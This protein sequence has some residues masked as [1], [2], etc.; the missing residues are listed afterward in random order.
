[1][2]RIILFSVLFSISFSA[3]LLVPTEYSTIQSGIDASADGDTVL[4]SA[5]TYNESLLLSGKNIVLESVEGP[6][7]TIIDAGQQNDRALLIENG[8]NNST[9]ISGFR[10]DN[11]TVPNGSTY[12]GGIFCNYT[13]PIIKNCFFNHNYAEQGGAVA[14]YVSEGAQIINSSFL[15]NDAGDN[16][17]AIGIY[18][19]SNVLIDS[20]I[21]TGNESVNYGGAF[22]VHSSGGNNIPNK[23]SNSTITNNYAEDVG[24]GL[25]IRT[26]SDV[27]IENCIIQNN[28]TDGLGGGIILDG[29]SLEIDNSRVSNNSAA[30]DGGGV[31]IYST[32]D[33]NLTMTG[34][35]L[36]Y[37]IAGR[38]GAIYIGTNNVFIKST[39]INGN[40]ADETGGI[41]VSNNSSIVPT[42]ENTTLYNNT[43]LVTSNS[44]I[45][46]VRGTFKNLIIWGNSSIGADGEIN[47]PNEGYIDLSYSLVPFDYQITKFY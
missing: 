34:T 41:Y 27:I 12:G 21:V 28:T 45:S 36:S 20:C 8:I 1:M 13:S 46:A 33:G 5:G 47:H 43:S 10:I 22:D 38:A 35:E 16:G 17:G 18:F 15:G 7:I 31:Y 24:G 42:I 3:T 14:F 4:V 2:K 23:I 39:L 40:I 30:N 37:N 32:A 6:E 25:Q 44:A 29:S 11:G 19:S 9:V 26:G